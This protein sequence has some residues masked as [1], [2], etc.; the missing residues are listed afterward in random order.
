MQRVMETSEE[1]THFVDA[2]GS[3]TQLVTHF[4]MRVQTPRVFG[5]KIYI[6]AGTLFVGIAVSFCYSGNG[7]PLTIGS[8]IAPRINLR[9]DPFAYLRCSSTRSVSELELGGG[10]LVLSQPKAQAEDVGRRVENQLELLLSL[11]IELKGCVS[12][13]RRPNTKSPKLAV[14]GVSVSIM[15]QTMVCT[16]R[17]VRLFASR[18]P[19][20]GVDFGRSGVGR[21]AKPCVPALSTDHG[22]KKVNRAMAGVFVY[23]VLGAETFR[24]GDH[25]GRSAVQEEL[26][27]KRTMLELPWQRSF[28]RRAIFVYTAH[29]E[30]AAKRVEAMK[31]F[32]PVLRTSGRRGRA[33]FPAAGQPRD[34]SPHL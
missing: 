8:C 18:M 5:M 11:H 21:E 22:V 1:S 16:G 6:L 12:F 30:I 10:T 20:N 15:P 3:V 24:R 13:G 23:F 25:R 28:P 19:Q 34:P 32:H 33:C 4:E 9:F 2:T 17:L 31:I 26:A 7:W 29:A 14:F 27:G